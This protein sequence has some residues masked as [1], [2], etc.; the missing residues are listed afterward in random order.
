[1][2]SHFLDTVPQWAASLETPAQEVKTSQSW[3]SDS[4]AILLSYYY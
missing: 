1:M 2:N 3:I 4:F